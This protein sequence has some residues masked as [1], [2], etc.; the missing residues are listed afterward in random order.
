[1]GGGTSNLYTAPDTVV[2]ECVMEPYLTP[3][4]GGVPQEVEIIEP[5]EGDDDPFDF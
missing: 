5:F 1:M 4:S 3:I 2:L